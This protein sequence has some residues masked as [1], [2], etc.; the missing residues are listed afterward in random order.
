[1]RSSEW[2]YNPNFS[3]VPRLA[4]NGQNAHMRGNSPAASPTGIYPSLD[5]FRVH[6][7]TGVQRQNTASGAVGVKGPFT[8]LP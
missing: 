1:M 5:A 7:A 3:S 8:N 6:G 2:G 4:V